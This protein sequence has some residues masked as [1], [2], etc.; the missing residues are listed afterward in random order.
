MSLNH[1][2]PHRNE[3]EIFIVI[4]IY[5]AIFVALFFAVGLLYI[6]FR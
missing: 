1:W 5:V 2:N 3:P 6:N 4:G